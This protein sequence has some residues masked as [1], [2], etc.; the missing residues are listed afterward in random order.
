MAQADRLQKQGIR[1]RAHTTS[2]TSLAWLRSQLERVPSSTKSQLLG[3][4][5]GNRRRTDGGVPRRS[6][7]ARDLDGSSSLYRRSF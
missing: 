6:K 3:N 5:Q 7:N 2:R 1:R 4:S